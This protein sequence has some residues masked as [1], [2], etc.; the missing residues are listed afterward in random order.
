MV[1]PYLQMMSCGKWLHVAVYL[2]GFWYDLTDGGLGKH[3]RLPPSFQVV[4]SWEVSFEEETKYLNR[5][6]A[7]ARSGA[8][9]GLLD[10][11]CFALGVGNPTLCTSLIG[12]VL[13]CDTPKIPAHLVDWALMAQ[14]KRGG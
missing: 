1:K 13:G 11:A 10:F 2:N 4:A 14:L 9:V 3:D 8:K 6:D 12:A 7:V 5:L